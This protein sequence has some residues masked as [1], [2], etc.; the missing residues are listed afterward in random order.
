M[1]G[2]PVPWEHG[3]GPWEA[4][5]EFL[6]THDEFV[7]D[8]ECEKFGLSFNPNGYLLRIK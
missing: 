3:D 5:D 4:V 2:H 6:K 1:N 8:K 7:V